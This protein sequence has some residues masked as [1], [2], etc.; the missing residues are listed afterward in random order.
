MKKAQYKTNPSS[1]HYQ[2]LTHARFPLFSIINH[3]GVERIH[4][5]TLVII[6]LHQKAGWVPNTF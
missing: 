5:G 4:S 3:G 1:Q 6:N 2:Y